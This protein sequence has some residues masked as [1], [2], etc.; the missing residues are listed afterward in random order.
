MPYKYTTFFK[1]ISISI[2]YL[3]LNL[4]LS[5]GL[6]LTNPAQLESGIPDQYKLNFLLFN[7][8]WFY[9]SHL[10]ELYQGVLSREAI[11]TIKATA[12]A[13]AMYFS[14]LVALQL[15]LKQLPLSFEFVWLSSFLFGFVLLTVK[16]AF[17]FIRK[18]KRHLLINYKKVVIIGAGKTGEKIRDYINQ[19]PHLGYKVE[20]FFDDKPG[21]GSNLDILGC[22][23]Q[24]FPQAKALGVSEVFYTLPNQDKERVDALIHEADKNMMRFRLVPE[25]NLF[26]E[27]NVFIDLNGPVPI[28]TNRQEP[29]EDRAN[30]LVKRVFDLLVSS[31][32]IVFILSWLIPVMAVIIKLESRGP[33][34]FRQLRSGRYNKPFYCFKF[35]SMRLNDESDKKQASK[36]DARVTKV[37]AF[38]RK[39]SIDELPQFLNVLM[40][41]MSVIGP[42][43]HM[44][45]HTEDYSA[46]F[47]EYMV[48]HYL[49]PGISGWAQV[50]G[51]RGETKD[52]QSM[53][54]RVMADIWYMENWSLL[55]DL[56]IMFLTIWVTFKGDQDAY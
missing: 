43:P 50:N 18:T 38:I 15:T 4:S 7:L 20:G 23:D 14:G 48:R 34:F 39:T 13:L 33:V 32:V 25:I 11:P 2:D 19:T 45:K 53:Q 46:L 51:F 3:F 16:V 6:L 1:W 22:I 56:K 27:K 35:R 28:L 41:D 26:Q 29:L 55:L 31:L 5:I 9:C 52:V 49:S 21:N 44:L 12:L 47:D 24:C 8:M 37:G 42:R 17:L 36:G 30:R 10:V 40:G 54:K